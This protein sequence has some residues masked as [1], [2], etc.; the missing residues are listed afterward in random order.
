[1]SSEASQ[2]IWL[3]LNAG[4]HGWQVGGWSHSSPS[5]MDLLTV[6]SHELGHLLGLPDLDPTTHA[7]D[8]MA[9]RLSVGIQRSPLELTSQSLTTLDLSRPLP[10][11]LRLAD[12]L[13]SGLGRV[14]LGR[15][16]LLPMTAKSDLL[17]DEAQPLM[18]LSDALDRDLDRVVADRK[19][20]TELTG[21]K[22]IE[23]EQE[24]DE[25][26]A[27]VDELFGDFDAKL[28]GE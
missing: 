7:G 10:S 11:P 20:L 27:K 5:G 2:T 17:D 3:D 6:V 4:G 25:L 18:L 26:F 12:N 16:V 28:L 15:G 21:Q 24:L 8:L 19:S 9:S 22:R 23:H 14:E 13:F 1:L